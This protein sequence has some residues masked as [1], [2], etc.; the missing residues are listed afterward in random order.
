MEQVTHKTA[1][2]AE[3]SAAAAEQ[4]TAQ[5]ESMNQLAAELTSLV[6]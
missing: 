4:L 6:G 2:E 3:E 5:S 1:A